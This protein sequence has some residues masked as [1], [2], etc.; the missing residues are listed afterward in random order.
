MAKNADFWASA[1]AMN[2]FMKEK[3]CL[4]EDAQDPCSGGIIS[5]HTIARSQL[6][7]IAVN[8]HVK[9]FNVSA[10]QLEKSDGKISVKDAGVN[11]FS[12]LNCFCAKHDLEI[13]SEIEN[14]SLTFAAKQLAVLH[15]RAA[16]SELYRKMQVH[17]G[18]LNNIQ[19]FQKKADGKAQVAFLEAFAAG[20]DLG[21]RDMS[22]ALEETWKILTEGNHG[23]LEAAVVRFQKTPSI[24]T[25]GSFFPEVDF[26]GRRLSTL[27]QMDRK[28]EL[29][30]FH[31]LAE[32]GGTAA[33]LFVWKK[34]D[35]TGKSLVE[36]YLRQ[37]SQLYTT[38][39]IQFA[40][41]CFENTCMSPAWWDGLKKV[42]QDVLVGRMSSIAPVGTAYL[43]YSGVT[44]DEW[45]FDSVEFVA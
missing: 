18:T 13:F 8:G 36:S 24:M 32:E 34:G 3:M 14:V 40:F 10:A 37:P 25:V 31:I 6:S 28:Y 35:A 16:A 11:Q 12:T 4:A 27:G 19:E 1:E 17:K 42:E 30:S 44:H 26:E 22:N 15:Y 2:R 23:T 41:E 39:A 21:I 38:L 7:K 33:V 43:T 5:A 9:S 20:E 29:M 45:I